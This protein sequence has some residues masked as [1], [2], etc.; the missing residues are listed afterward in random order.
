MFPDILLFMSD[1]HTPYYSGFYGGNVDTP[2]LDKLCADGTQFTEAYTVCPLCVPSRLAMLSGLRPGKTGIFTLNDALPDMTPTF[3]HNLVEQGYE[4][5]LLGRMHF[6]GSDQ[7]HGFTKRLAPDMTPVTW[8]RP[9]KAL[10]RERG[11]TQFGFNEPNC[12]K[13]IGG[14]ESPVEHYDNLVIEET[15]RYLS[16]S[17]DK[18][19]FIV[20]GIY[21]PHF[22]YIAPRELFEKYIKRVKLPA[23]FMDDPGSLLRGNVQENVDE[24]AALGA[25]AAYCAMIERMDGKVAKV[26]NAFNVFSAKRGA[27]AIFCY[28]SDHGD[29]C[30]DRRLFGKSTF[31]EKSAKIPLIFAGA[32]IKAGRK[33]DTPV[34][35][36]DI[37]PT[38][39][40]CTGAKP[41]LDV[42]GVSVY[43]ALKGEELEPHAVYGEFLNR[44]NW[45]APANKYC[46]MLKDGRYKYLSFDEIEAEERL[47]DT[48]KDPDERHN[49]IQE[50]KEIADKMRSAAAKLKMRDE[51]LRLQRLH[52]RAAELFSTF[53][54]AIG[55]NDGEERW[56]GNPP[57]ARGNPEICIRGVN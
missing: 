17:H 7:R 8:N 29:Q 26:R 41:M 49:L 37:G 30:G 1:Q 4:T 12:M 27:P 56:K 15:L 20:V 57:Y 9:V 52:N 25:Q 2:A 35:I 13:I 55:I 46:F 3:L 16:E 18:P 21:G 5:V 39:L 11:V 53:E 54:N 51:A 28:T 23:S 14:G 22:P 10:Q 43:K 38:M 48:V 47:Y 40:E 36:M 33:V 44:E 31:Y 19:Q 32:G 45:Q 6:L 24:E 42:D 50:E 34:S